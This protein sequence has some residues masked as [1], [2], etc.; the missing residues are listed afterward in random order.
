MMLLKL[1]VEK[2]AMCKEKQAMCK[3][4]QAMRVGIITP[5]K[6]QK[7][8]IKETVKKELDEEMKTFIK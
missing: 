3:E 2:R 8:C 5:Y 1:F 6:A 7:E 4:K